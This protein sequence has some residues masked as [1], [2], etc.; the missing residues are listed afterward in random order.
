[1]RRTAIP[2]GRSAVASVGE[3]SLAVGLGLGVAVFAIGF[4]L[5]GSAGTAVHPLAMAA[6]LSLAAIPLIRWA[7]AGDPTPQLIAFVGLGLKALGTIAR[8]R[9]NAG[10][11]DAG[12]YHAAGSLLSDLLSTGFVGPDDPQLLRRGTGTNHV[13]YLVGWLYHFT[14]AR[15]NTAYVVWSFLSFVGV[16]CFYKSATEAI[17]QLDRTRYALLVFLMPSMLFW[18]SS[19]GKD[20]IMVGCMGVASLGAAALARHRYSPIRLVLLAAG[21]GLSAWI[22]PHVTALFILALAAALIWPR[23]RSGK[24]VTQIFFAAFLLLVLTFALGQAADYFGAERFEVTA[25]LDHAAERTSEGGSEFTPVRVSGPASFVL[26]AVTVLLRPLA[27]EANSITQL[28][29]SLEGMALVAIGIASFDRLRTVPR[30]FL[31]NTYVRLC[32][33][34]TLG[35]IMAFSVISNFGLLARQRAQLWPLLL[36]L[37]AL[38]SA[39]AAMQ[40]PVP[41]SGAGAAEP[42]SH[43]DQ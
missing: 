43:A 3:A 41:R 18:P 22:R 2:I 10:G 17:P 26:A 1:M 12:F 24:A 34:Y 6:L 11:A 38:P 19:L 5:S 42:R 20:A 9:F 7:T 13:S 31:Q 32:V 35:F 14:G 39:R 27:F 33:I 16:V 37:F 28:A 23:R 21:L 25:L 36:V 8:I 40:P 29:T 4:S 15:I 30:M